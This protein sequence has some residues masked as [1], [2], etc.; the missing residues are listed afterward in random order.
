M[1]NI[2]RWTPSVTVAAVIED[3]GRFL[4]VEEHTPEGLR[5]NNPAGHLD[6][7]E[8]PEQGVVREALEETARVFTPHA[9][10]GVYMSRFVRPATAE[11]VTY[12]R[13]AYSGTVGEPLPGRVLDTGIVR[14]LWMT[15]DEVRASTAR[16]RSA[17]VLQCI[18]DHVDGKRHPLAL[19]RTDANVMVPQV[20]GGSTGAG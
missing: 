7:G 10:V 18:Q 17:L 5:L 11:D 1:T 6:E 19:V 13:F 14:T 2:K 8:S 20:M 9:L 15:L 12:V 4:L 3:Q 16:H